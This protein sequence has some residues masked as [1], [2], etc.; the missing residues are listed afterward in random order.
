MPSFG[1]EVQH[2]LGQAGAIA[3]LETFVNKVR[4]QY[5]GQVSNLTEEWN[6]HELTF[7]F[8][9]YG[10]Q[11]QG[12]LT[13]EEALVRMTGTLPFAAIAFKGKIE[14]SLADEL[15]KALSD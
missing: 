10:I 12:T 4:E 8:S 7:S 1:S 11:I 5:Q 3:R 14:S 2:Q 9:A 6:D 15:Q 13:V